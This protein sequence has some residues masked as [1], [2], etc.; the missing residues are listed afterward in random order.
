MFCRKPFIFFFKSSFAYI[1]V[2]LG[3]LYG[4]LFTRTLIVFVPKTAIKQT[5]VNGLF[6]QK[7]KIE[8]DYSS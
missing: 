5:Y 6:Y 7:R 8:V 3:I 4:K 1:N 2:F